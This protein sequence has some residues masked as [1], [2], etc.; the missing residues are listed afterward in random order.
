MIRLLYSL[1]PLALMAL[2]AVTAFLLSRLSKR[3][4]EIEAKI[5]VEAEVE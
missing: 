4:P 3:M 5:A 1:I 2:L